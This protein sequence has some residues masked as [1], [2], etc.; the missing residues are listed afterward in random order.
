MAGHAVKGD[1]DARDERRE[2]LDGPPRRH[3]RQIQ[4]RRAT[5]SPGCDDQRHGHIT[6]GGQHDIWTPRL[7]ESASLEHSAPLGQEIP[8]HIQRI[9]ATNGPHTHGVKGQPCP[10][11]DSLLHAIGAPHPSY[12]KPSAFLICECLQY[13]ESR[14]N[15]APCTAAR[16]QYAHLT[17]HA[18]L[19][20]TQRTS[21]Q[22]Q[23]QRERGTKC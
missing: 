17:P 21:P 5:S 9:G 22:P 18:S 23:K 8:R 1:C 10:T 11:R 3:V 16:H 15:V 7:D 6:P 12:L 19:A 14:I 4:E 2:Q 13:R 20:I